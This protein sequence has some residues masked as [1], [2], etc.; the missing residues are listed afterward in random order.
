MFFDV[1]PEKGNDH[2]ALNNK[3]EI[4]KTINILKQDNYNGF[5]IIEVFSAK[6]FLSSLKFLSELGLSIPN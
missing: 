6:N 1:N 3:F 4:Q 2:S 5:I